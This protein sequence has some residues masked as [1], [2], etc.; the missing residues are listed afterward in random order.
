MGIV[1]TLVIV[2]DLYLPIPDEVSGILYFI[3]IGIAASA[4]LNNYKIKEDKIK[5]I[6]LFSDWA[7]KDRDIGMEKNHLPAVQKMIDILLMDYR[8]HFSFVDVGC[9]NGYVVRKIS[10]LKQCVI[11]VG[12]DGAEGMIKKQKKWI[13]TA[14]IIV[15]I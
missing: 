6:D 14:I 15:R 2:A 7:I 1:A 9:G 12:M 13:Q 11:S 4:V 10:E 3:G 8:R 5:A